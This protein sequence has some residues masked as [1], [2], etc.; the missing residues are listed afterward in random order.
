MEWIER[1]NNAINYIE[2]N[3]T[4]DIDYEQIAAIACCSTYHF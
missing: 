3:I 1:L 2:E 4:E